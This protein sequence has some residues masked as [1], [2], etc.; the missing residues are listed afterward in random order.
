MTFQLEY[1]EL[2]TDAIDAIGSL[3]QGWVKR[4][5]SLAEKSEEA[6]AMVWKEYRAG[7]GSELDTITPQLP[8]WMQAHF[9]KFSALYR[10]ASEVERAFIH[11]ENEVSEA[12]RLGLLRGRELSDPN[13]QEW[14]G[15]K[16]EFDRARM[17]D[18]IPWWQRFTI[19]RET[20]RYRSKEIAMAKWPELFTS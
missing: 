11:Y 16:T 3:F 7:D 4:V 18:K 2:K 20:N 1:N 10:F 5:D 15:M 17:L 6:W 14:R 12:Y 9:A 19:N 8:E 13:P